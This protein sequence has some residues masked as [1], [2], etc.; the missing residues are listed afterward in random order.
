LLSGHDQS[1]DEDS[2]R[3][4]RAILARLEFTTEDPAFTWLNTCFVVGEGEL[5]GD[6]E[7]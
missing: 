5:D 6:S 4:L 3:P 7:Q 1:I 2:P